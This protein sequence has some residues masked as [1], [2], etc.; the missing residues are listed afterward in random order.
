MI[1]RILAAAGWTREDV[2]LY[3]MHQ[4]TG[5]MLEHLR[6]RLNLSPEQAPL[7]LE[8][9]GNT[10]SSTLPLLIQDLRAGGRLRPGV[11]TLLIG[12]GVGLSWAGCGWTEVWQPRGQASEKP[13][14][15]EEPAGRGAAQTRIE[16]GG[17]N[18]PSPSGRGQGEG[19]VA[20]QASS[21]PA[22]LPKGEGRHLRSP[23][24]SRTT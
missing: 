11:Q 6:A 5:F 4:A 17:K 21:P 16:A 22:L 7:A 19:R 9:Y 15:K 13:A 1:D 2:A 23:F 12:F 20:S 14:A 3:L 10:V 24:S 18:V 8:Q